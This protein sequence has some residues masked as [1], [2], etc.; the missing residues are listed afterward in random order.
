[1]MD[2]KHCAGCHSSIYNDRANCSESDCWRLSAAK[3]VWRKEV[4][5]DQIPPWNQK[6]IRVPDCYHRQR[7]LY[8]DPK[9]IR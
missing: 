4:H 6:A 8:I 9:R 2:K 1:M 3:L 7:Y 5:I